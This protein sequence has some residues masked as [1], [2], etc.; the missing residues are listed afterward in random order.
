VAH[1]GLGSN[2][3]PRE[4]TLELAV[5]LL[6][7]HESIE[8]RSRSSLI[9]TAPVGGPEGQG[10]YIN[11]VVEVETSL[12]PLRLLLFLQ[13]VEKDLGRNRDRE[14]RMGPRTCDLDILLLGDLVMDTPEL[15]V[16]HPRMAE[17]LFVL[18]PMAEIAPDA[19]HP[20]LGLTISEMLRLAGNGGSE[21]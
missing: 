12:D 2:V 13:S 3:G 11:A 16:P 14:I 10:D 6:G 4:K 17:R 15:T 9:E 20:V 8:V 18:E 19:V 21:T 1:I 7:L 5:A